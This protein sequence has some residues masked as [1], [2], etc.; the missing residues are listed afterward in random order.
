MVNRQENIFELDKATVGRVAQLARLA[1][2]ESETQALQ[3]ELGQI[4]GYFQR[5]EDLDTSAV[6]PA[7]HPYILENQLRADQVCPSMAREELLATAKRQKDGCLLV[8]R[9]VE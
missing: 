3:Q 4:L 8:P 1:P 2:G 7:Y 6:E 5:L 9:T